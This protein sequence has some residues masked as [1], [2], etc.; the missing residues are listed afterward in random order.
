VSDRA[1]E[2]LFSSLGGVIDDA[3]C[4]DL[5]AGS[6]AMGIEALSRGAATC[7]FVDRS[8]SATAA[9]TRNL[10]TTH[11]EDRAVVVSRDATAFLERPPSGGARVDL[12]FVDPPYDLAGPPF[13]RLF[14]LLASAW[15][16]ERGWT[17]VVT[18]GHKASLPAVPLHWTTRRQL[19]YGDSLL[20]LYGP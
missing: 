3:V 20:I 7:T 19:R 4:L 6:G 10:S 18:R 13:E 9:V 12:V 8:R 2:G 15:L 11:L 14:E 5:F 16:P 1:R 17:V